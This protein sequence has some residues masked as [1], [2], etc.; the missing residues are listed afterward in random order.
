VMGVALMTGAGDAH[1]D[2]MVAAVKKRL[3]DDR[4][5]R[6]TPAGSA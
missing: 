5:A 4:L 2:S 6:S 1:L 3:A